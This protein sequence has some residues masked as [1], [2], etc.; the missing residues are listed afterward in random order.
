MGR[1]CGE[2]ENKRNACKISVRKAEG[3]IPIRGYV[4][5]VE[6]MIGYFEMRKCQHLVGAFLKNSS[7][8]L[9]QSRN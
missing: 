7:I 6:D 2:H 8:I 4:R 9:F 1:A 5:Y 3:Y